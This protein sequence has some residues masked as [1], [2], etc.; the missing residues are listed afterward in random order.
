MSENIDKDFLKV[1]EVQSALDS[2]SY[3]E[4]LGIA[5]RVLADANIKDLLSAGK[6]GL[7][8][9]L[10]SRLLRYSAMIEHSID[11][12]ADDESAEVLLE[13]AAKLQEVAWAL[14]NEM[15]GID[16][17]L[18]G[19]FKEDPVGSTTKDSVSRI[20]AEFPWD[21]TTRRKAG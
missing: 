17:T 8:D 13:D 16:E 21:W 9:E 10:V 2:R 4:A 5:E 7:L 19:T 12:G 18:V 6:F 11:E 14:V 15:N 20:K 3:K 1:S